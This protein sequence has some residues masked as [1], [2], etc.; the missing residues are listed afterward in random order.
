MSKKNLIGLL[1]LLFLF[2]AALIAMN[3]ARSGT[4]GVSLMWTPSAVA[5]TANPGS[6]QS[7]PVTLT[8]LADVSGV[9]V[10][11][12][13]ELRGVVSVTPTSFAMLRSGQAA[14]VTLTF[15]SSKSEALH[16]AQGTIHVNSGTST[17]AK[18][19]PV[20]I[21]FVA[22]Q[23][24]NGVTVP[25]EPPLGLNNATLAGFDANN[26]GVRDDVE[27]IIAQR[28]GGTS[29]FAFAMAYA[30]VYQSEVVNPT[31]TN[32]HDAL[33][34]TAQEYC[35]AETGSV[36]VLNFPMGDTVLNTSARKAAMR[37]FND[38]RM[39]YSSLELRGL[40]SCLD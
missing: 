24:I 28:F 25:P 33:V 13:P 3:V 17:L 7:F 4:P 40:A 27:R 10:T 5:D 18:T 9:T 8:P 21:T 35:A 15:A 36:D 29:D 32:R 23:I 16:T 19:L 22:P 2:A 1:A 30:K 26:N 20:T 12:V 11:V 38:V 6:R 34:L 14:T 37:A 39:L 31:P